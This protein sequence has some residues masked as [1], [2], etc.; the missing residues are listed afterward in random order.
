VEKGAKS[1]KVSGNDPEENFRE[2]ENIFLNSV[3]EPTALGV[4][5]LAP[6]CAC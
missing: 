5:I 2:S 3:T 1:D 4:V 6:R